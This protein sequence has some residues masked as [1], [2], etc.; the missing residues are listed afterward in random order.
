MNPQH[1]KA[2]H[3]LL[4]LFLVFSLHAS[5]QDTVSVITWN[6]LSIDT[7]NTLKVPTEQ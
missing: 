1:R 3:L 4:P 2:V 7:S 5:A 6:L